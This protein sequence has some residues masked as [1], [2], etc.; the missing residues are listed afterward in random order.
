[1][2]LELVNDVLDISAIEGGHRKLNNDSMDFRVLFR[3]CVASF[4]RDLE[5]KATELAL[6]I[7]SDAERLVAD[8]RVIKQIVLNLLSNAVKFTQQN[9]VINL[10][11]WSEPDKTVIVVED[12]GIGI[13]KDK[14]PSI[15]KPFTQGHDDPHKA[16]KG[17]GLGLSI[18]NYL[19]ELHGR[20]MTIHSIQDKGTKVP[21]RISTKL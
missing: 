18:V 16:Q 11:A 10:I 17:T 14:L 12:N 15:T 4:Q 3:E 7:A 13:P 6:D 1:M 8:E 19:V 5:N 21:I 20:N 2:I 9:E